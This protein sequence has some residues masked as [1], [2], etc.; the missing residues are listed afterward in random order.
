MP[1]NEGNPVS[2]KTPVRKL[3]QYIS[4]EVKGL[5]KI[6]A[7]NIVSANMIIKFEKPRK[8]TPQEYNKQLSAI[9]API[10]DLENVYFTLHSGMKILGSDLVYTHK[11]TLEDEIITP[12]T[13]IKS[14][15][16][17][18]ESIEQV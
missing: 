7:A 13:Y 9:L 10:Q 11:E 6:I 5:N 17:V 8:M 14:M 16:A 15:R 1:Q 2:I 3:F 18:L 4:P 12:L